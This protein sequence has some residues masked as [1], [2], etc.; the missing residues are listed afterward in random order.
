M[1]ISFY[2]LLRPTYYIWNIWSNFISLK[3]DIIEQMF[4]YDFIFLA[5][6]CRYYQ[7][8]TFD[9]VWQKSLNI[10]AV[11]YTLLDSIF[12]SSTV[13]N[14]RKISIVS[15]LTLTNAQISFFFIYC[16]F[17][18]HFFGILTVTYTLSG[19]ILYSWIF[20]TSNMGN[21]NCVLQV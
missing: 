3:F 17:D 10:A 4:S 13:Q 8:Q 5:V 19:K 15:A 2:I 21:I 6:S 1:F 20:V 16:M 7:W 9:S 14:S 11:T 12:F 18:I